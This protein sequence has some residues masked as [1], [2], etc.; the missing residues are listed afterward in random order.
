MALRASRKSS[1]HC[2]SVVR[3]PSRAGAASVSARALRPWRPGI[4]ALLG[5]LSCHEARTNR[6]L[7]AGSGAREVGSN[8]LR[9]DYAGSEACAGCHGDVYAA[10]KRSPMHRMTRALGS[11]EVRAP[12]A[13]DVFAFKGDSATMERR[14]AERYVRLTSASEGPVL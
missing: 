5:L 3:Q 11:A 10:W 2:S 12:F 6:A 7:A 1:L 9:A 4:V 8:V 13:G 14:G